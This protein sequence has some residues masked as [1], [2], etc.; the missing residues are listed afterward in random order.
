MKEVTDPAV[1]KQ[2][3]GGPKEVTDPEVLKKLGGDEQ[4][5][6]RGLTDSFA[7]GV[8]FGLVDEVGAAGGATGRSLKQLT[9]GEPITWSENYDDILAKK[10]RQ[11]K[12]F[13]EQNP[14]AST[15]ANVAGGFAN[16]L[17]KLPVSGTLGQQALQGGKIGVAMGAGYGAGTSEGDLT[18]RGQDALTQGVLGGVLGASAPVVLKGLSSSV[19]SAVAT[20][21][22]ALSKNGVSAPEKKVAALIR[23][24]GNGDLK[25]GL[26][27]VKQKIKEGGPD[28]VLAD[29]LGIGGQKFARASAN[30]PGR[31]A[32]IA[33]DFIGGRMSGRGQR[34]QQAADTLAPNSFHD[35][36]ARITQERS[37]AAQPLYEKAFQPISDKAGKVMAQW[38]DR[39]QQFLDDP[40]IK[41]GMS[42][43]VRIQ[44]LEAL[45]DNKPFNF[46]EYAIKGF[47]DAGE[48]VIEGTPNLRAMDAA[49]RGLD[50]VLEGYRDKTTGKL[51]LDEYGRAVEKVRKALVGKL[52]D[53][54]TDEAGY[55]AYRAA[56]EAWSGPSRLIDAGYKGRNF[57][58]GDVEI[59]KKTLSSMTDAEK[60]AFRLGVRRELSKMIETDTQTALSK[61]ADKKQGL[62]NKLEAVFPDKKSFGEFRKKVTAEAKKHQLEQFMSPRGNSHTTPLKEDIRDLGRIPESSLQGLE[63]VGELVTGHPFRAIAAGA[64]PTWQ[65][66]T[67][68]SEKT[69]EGLSSLLLS[70][71][72]PKLTG[73][74]NRLLISPQLEQAAARGLLTSGSTR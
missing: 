34:L 17:A 54:S 22:N 68:P 14:V 32:A 71:Q 48:V 69:A 74:N 8:T 72:V 28:T 63:A 38:D 9:S 70:P 21:K 64:R 20:L 2:L 30:I 65:K 19:N 27:I 53:I 57:V 35:E 41:K 12:Q 6:F 60:D 37:T 10:R 40:I 50:E 73:Y 3:S 18:E 26:E 42:K 1:L 23:D 51:V 31:S 33:D 15:V 67:A 46:Q 58:K 47:D 43:G 61:F 13:A 5:Y 52:D 39:L 62:W 59:T 25:Q 55:S 29:V 16:P 4:G 24:V 56:R 49:K 45:A 7:A 44:Q 36:I 66:I 11:A